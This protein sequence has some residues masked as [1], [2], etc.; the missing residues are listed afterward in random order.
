MFDSN[1]GENFVSGF[2]L[3]ATS[4][5][6]NKDFF[7]PANVDTSVIST[8]RHILIA[9]TGFGSLPGA[10]TPDFTFDQS[11]TPFTGL[12]INPN[13]TNITINFSGSNDG[14]TFTGASLP[15]DGIH[16][17]T[18]ANAFGGIP[19]NP[20]N[21]GPTVNSP[22]NF[23]NGS[24]SVNL[25]TPT[26]TGDYNGNHV[27][28]AG[29]YAVWRKT[30]NN[31]ASPAGSGADGNSSG[32]IDAGDYTFWRARFG[33]AAG[34]GDMVGEAAPE[35]TSIALQLSWVLLVAWRFRKRS[36]TVEKSYV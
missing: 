13:A 28:D 31:P 27:V 25:S 2:R 22:T 20:T 8:N 34:S 1:P 9:T 4:D 15:K 35:P 14:M 30:L 10:V 24:G 7:F 16:S 19:N 17:L 3:R 6:V 36:A 33:N 21:I 12:F 26:P 23:H 18:D 32:T 11:T 29:D 5:G